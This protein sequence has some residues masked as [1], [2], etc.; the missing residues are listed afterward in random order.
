MFIKR[1]GIHFTNTFSFHKG[2]EK[3]LNYNLY[4]IGFV[5]FTWWLD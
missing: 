1:L 2:H 3:I 4:H 5:Q